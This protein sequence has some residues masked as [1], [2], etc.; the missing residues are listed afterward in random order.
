MQEV[1]KHLKRQLNVFVPENLSDFGVGHGD[2]IA[3]EELLEFI[4]VQSA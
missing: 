3:G 4:R 2:S 1:L